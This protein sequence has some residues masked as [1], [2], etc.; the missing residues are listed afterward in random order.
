MRFDVTMCSAVFLRMGNMG[1]ISTRSPGWWEG[2]NGVGA[3]A[4]AGV[5]VVAGLAAGDGGAGAAALGAAD[6]AG[7][8]GVAAGG[9]GAGA[10]GAGGVVL[11]G[12]GAEAPLLEDQVGVAE[13]SGPPE[14]A[15]GALGA[16]AGAAGA[17]VGAAAA[18]GAGAGANVDAVG[19]AGAGTDGALGAGADDGAAGAAGLGALGVDDPGRVSMWPRMSCFV[20]RP[21][22]P[23]PGTLLMSTLCSAAIFRTTGDDRVWRSSSG[24]ISPRGFSAGGVDGCGRA[25]AGG[26]LPRLDANDEAADAVDGGVNAAVEAGEDG[27]G[28][29]AAGGGGEDGAGAGAADEDEAGVD[30]AGVDGAGADGLGADVIAGAEVPALAAG[31]PSA[32]GDFGGGAADPGGTAAGALA[33]AAGAAVGATAAVSPSPMTPTTVLMG[34]VAP[35]ST[36][37]SLRTPEAGA[38][39]SASTLSV[40]ISK[41][42]SSRCTRSPTF[43]IHLVIVPSAMD[44]PIWGMMTSVIRALSPELTTRQSRGRRPLLPPASGL[45]AGSDADGS[46]ASAPRPWTPGGGPRTPRR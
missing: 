36:R 18:A 16:L 20:T 17:D 37:I 8:D 6:G 44:S 21:A 24:V 9:A 31:V 7:A 4:G 35:G 25:A 14:A 43:F 27:A 15:V 10:D 40:E 42:G 41:S 46:C 28:V 34:T 22:I 2:T 5:A 11:A 30:E 3:D 45:R 33:L 38:G 1:T 26:V 32:W 23:V 19:A 12:R 29:A 39:I 13:M